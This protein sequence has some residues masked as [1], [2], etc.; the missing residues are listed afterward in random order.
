MLS[1]CTCAIR[2][3]SGVLVRGGQCQYCRVLRRLD[4]VNRL[5]IEFGK[6]PYAVFITV[7]YATENLFTCGG[8]PTLYKPDL[9]S[10]LDRVRKKLPKITVYGVGEYGGRLFGTPEAE[11]DI[12]PHYHLAVFSDDAR[13]SSVVR[14]A[15]VDSWK[16]GHIHI[17]QLSAGLIDYITGYQSAKLTNIR[18][19]ETVKGLQIRPEFAW[20]SRR[21]AVGDISEDILSV[22]EEH[23]EVTH[24]N[25][26]GKLVVI[27][28]FLR[29]KAKDLLLKH[30]LDC[31][32]KWVVNIFGKK[33]FVPNNKVDFLEYERRK[34]EKKIETLQKL[35]E[36]E[37]AQLQEIEKRS[38][39]GSVYKK[40]SQIKSQLVHNFNSKARL[41]A[42]TK[43]KKV[44]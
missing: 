42:H 20:R 12:H 2:N 14:K 8:L 7:T 1:A 26:D 28:K 37:E 34:R 9:D 36:K 23:G 13:F 22:Q 27:P 15:F 32:G 44:L 11:R 35:R 19:M 43:G 17:L 24:L 41:R 10:L 39:T 16:L 40:R 29:F 21:P 38:M 4:D 18:S 31:S 6:R 25:V 3:S 30:G 33:K 5:K